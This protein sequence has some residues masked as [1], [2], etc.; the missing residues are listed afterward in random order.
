MLVHNTCAGGGGPISLDEALERAE[1]F[2]EP[3]VPMRFIET[4]S[5]VQAIQE[6]A[7]STGTRVTRRVCFDVNSNTPHVQQ[8]GSHLNLQTQFDGVIIQGGA[9]AAP[10][11][12]IDPT[13]ITPT[14]Y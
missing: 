11:I 8:L 6:F 1:Q 5:G 13:T 4:P 2:L 10:H 7:N 3:N 12:P 9:L 14:D